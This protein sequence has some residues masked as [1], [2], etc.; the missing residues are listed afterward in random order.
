[1]EIV[2][3]LTWG[4]IFVILI[5][6]I[7]AIIGFAFY[8]RIQIATLK[9]EVSVIKDSLKNSEQEESK[10]SSKLETQ[11]GDLSKSFTNMKDDFGTKLYNMNEKVTESSTIIRMKL[12]PNEKS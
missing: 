9:V 3:Q 2:N 10:T 7:A 8:V 6:Q 1:M 5:P 11:I 12:T 4:Q